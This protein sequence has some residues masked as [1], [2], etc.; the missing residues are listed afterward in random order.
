MN[1][2]SVWDY[3]DNL[4]Y[5]LPLDPGDPRLVPLNDARLKAVEHG[6]IADIF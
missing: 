3:R 2:P 1:E 5:D 6:K 4:D